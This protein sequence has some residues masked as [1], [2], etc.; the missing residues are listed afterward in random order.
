MAGIAVLVVAAVLAVVSSNKSATV[1]N[2]PPGAAVAT[3]A[4]PATEA[5]SNRSAPSAEAGANT[6]LSA[7]NK[8]APPQHKPPKPAEYPTAKALP[9]REGFVLSPYT[10]KIIDV[11]GL[12]S[13]TLVA[14]PEFSTQDKKF[15]RVP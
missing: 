9:D 3:A 14:D 5:P 2:Q 1:P 7:P 8:P 4:P 6:R 12:P 10:N 15:F 11:R 13:G